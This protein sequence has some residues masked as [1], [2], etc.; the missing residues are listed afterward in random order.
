[1]LWL[2][3]DLQ[4]KYAFLAV[5][6]VSSDWRLRYDRQQPEPEEHVLDPKGLACSVRNKYMRGC[7]NPVLDNSEF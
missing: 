2:K 7:K 6:A 1:M 5:S 3:R 4:F